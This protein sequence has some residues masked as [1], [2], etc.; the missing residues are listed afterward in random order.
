MS[1]KKPNEACMFL[2]MVPP[3]A[4]LARY[5]PRMLGGLYTNV[6]WYLREK[7][8][9][10]VL[11]LIMTVASTLVSLKS[12]HIRVHLRLER[13]VPIFLVKSVIVFLL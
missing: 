2:L 13:Y 3:S 9:D 6:C 11:Y 8:T 7:G 1:H 12:Y 4:F 10:K 5:L